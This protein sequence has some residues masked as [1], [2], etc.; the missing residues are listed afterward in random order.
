MSQFIS[1][2]KSNKWIILILI[3]ATILRLYNLDYQSLW[4]DEIYTLNVASPKHSFSQIISEVNLRESFPYLYFFIMNTM[5]TLFGDTSI[6]AR[7]PSVIFGIAAVWM[8]YKFG[9]ETYSKKVGLIAALLFTFNEYAI[10][11]SQDARAYSLY[12][13]CL[14]FSFY[15][16]VIFLKNNSQKN[17]IWFAVSA[18]LLV[19]VNFF[20]VLNVITQG[21]I[22]LF[23]LF[24]LDKSERLAY[25]KRLLVIAGIILLFF[26][27][28][29][30]KFYLLSQF[31][32]SWIP[33]PSNDGLTNIL[34]EFISVSEILVFVYGILFTFFIIK[35]F[36]QKRTKSIKEIIDNKLVFNYLLIA[37]WISFVIVVILLKSY[38]SSSLYVSRYFISIFPAII[39]VIS[40]ALVSIK[41]IQVRLSF[42]ALLVFF[43]A[44]DLVVVKK[45]YHTPLKAQ[46]REA[47]DMVKFYNPNKDVVYTSLKYWYNYFLNNHGQKFEVVDKP[48]LTVLVKEMQANPALLKSFWIVD[49][50]QDIVKL[51]DADQQFLDTHFR[52]QETYDGLG[53]IARHYIKK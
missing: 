35:V 24:N 33:A 50:Y 21:F 26:I 40:I 2:V 52:L 10:F 34:K 36:N 14:L 42:L 12:L 7:I 25:F 5:F 53:A 28:N 15:R 4:M 39:L 19:N 3:V 18:G 1:S 32:S 9:K 47:S 23:V 37:A 43:M 27:P 8:M 17:M 51:S 16:F 46:F 45:Y 20:S 44:F 38:L 6:V 13:L 49:G 22:L 30:Y 11:H 29:A 31:K 41:N 48:N